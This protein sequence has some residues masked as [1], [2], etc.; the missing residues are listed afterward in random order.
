[1]PFVTEEIYGMLPIK[2]AESIMISEYPK[3]DKK[4]IFDIEEDAVDNAVDFIKNFRN[5]K[6]ENNISKDAKVMFDTE[7]DNELIVKMLKIKDNIV[8]QP[9]G[10]KAYRVFS[11]RINATIYFEKIETEAEK[12]QKKQQIEDLK[13]SIAR[14][15]K[16]LANE[17][18]INKA[19]AKIVES[20]KQKLE[21]E[22]NK[23]EEL[24]K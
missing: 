3:Y 21:D 6:A 16:L 20:D 23:L 4:Y 22:K 5:V 14:R 7:D 24:L 18:Y 9:L 17:N 15:E 10:I 8:K 19:P 11:N 2:D 1:M 12:A 13:N